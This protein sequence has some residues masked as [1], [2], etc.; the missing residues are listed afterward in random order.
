MTA[1]LPPYEVHW[2]PATASE[3]ATTPAVFTTHYPVRLTD[4]SVL[5]LL[6]GPCRAVSRPSRC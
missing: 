5:D 2:H 6:C 4:G 1:T 3:T